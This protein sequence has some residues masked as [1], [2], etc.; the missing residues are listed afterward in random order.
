MTVAVTG[1]DR[2]ITDAPLRMPFS[3]GNV[4][5]TQ[6]PHLFVRVAIDTPAGTATGLAADGLSP[7]WFVKE[8]SFRDGFDAM[9]AVIDHA[10]EVAAHVHPMESS[11]EVWRAIYERQQTWGEASPHPPLLWSYGVSLIERA[12]IDAICRSHGLPFH[13][14]LA[15]NTFDIDLGYFHPELA[16]NSPTSY[17]PGTPADRVAVRHTVGLTDPLVAEDLTV[18]NRVDDGLPQTLCEH[19]ETHEVEHFKLKIGGQPEQ[20]VARLRRIGAVLSASPLDSYRITL[21]ANEQYDSAAAF[22]T[23]WERMEGIS[24]LDTLCERIDF[25]EQPL[26][27]NEALGSETERVL[28][29]W[30]DRP[31]L[32]I[33]ESDDRIDSCARALACGYDGTSHKNVKG[34][35]KGIANACRIRQLQASEEGQ[36]VL[37]CEDAANIGPVAL[38][39]DLAVVACLG[40]GHVER[41][42]HQFFRGL[43]M[44]PKAIQSGILE[45]HPDLYERHPDGFAT[46]SIDE[47]DLLLDTANGAPFGY[48]IEFDPA[49]FT[50]LSE[51]SLTLSTTHD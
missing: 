28:D 11:F 17:L 23:F 22:R 36:Y 27:R 37:S 34:V 14:A 43:S 29:D 33:D 5:V 20:D 16:C 1:I 30:D 15:T 45:A 41:N 40:V 2:Y 10:C 21:D 25:V 3:F 13:E 51:W 31:A 32:I 24:E 42:G 47:G 9:L 46:V 12:L 38:P 6:Q 18:D 50:P 44:F 19:I 35:F 26:P 48:A 4:T 39:Q 8:A 7:L 49:Q